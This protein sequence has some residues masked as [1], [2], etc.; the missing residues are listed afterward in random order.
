MRVFSEHGI[1][2]KDR[3]NKTTKSIEMFC[4]GCKSIPRNTEIKNHKAD[5]D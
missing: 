4:L 3:Y 2:I 1:K 5:N